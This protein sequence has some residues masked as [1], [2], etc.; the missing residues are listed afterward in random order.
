MADV[1]T[2]YVCNKDSRGILES[3]KG[4][5]MLHGAIINRN[6]DE[7]EQRC[8]D[9]KR[10]RKEEDEDRIA[11]GRR[12]S[13][14]RRETEQHK[15]RECCVTGGVLL[16]VLLDVQFFQLPSRGTHSLYSS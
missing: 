13:L 14:L 9:A 11:S 4:K 3:D 2:S 7:D 16:D 15:T 12:L 6:Q 10:R 1:C 8:K 5:M